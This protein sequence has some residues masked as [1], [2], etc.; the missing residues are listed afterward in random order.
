MEAVLN[1]PKSSPILQTPICSRQRE[2]RGE[3][4]TEERSA[5]SRQ[6][7]RGVAEKGYQLS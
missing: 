7:L 4:Q 3:K 6:R 5:S 2:D 1:G